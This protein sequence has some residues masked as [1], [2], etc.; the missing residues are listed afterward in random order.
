MNTPNFTYHFRIFVFILF[1]M[2]SIPKESFGAAYYEV[3]VEKE[4]ILKTGKDKKRRTDKKLKKVL[5]WQLV[6]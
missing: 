5:P 2:L 3:T 4:T 1:G 6:Y